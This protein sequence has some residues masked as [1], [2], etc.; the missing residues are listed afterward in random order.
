MTSTPDPKATE[1][2]DVLVKRADE[3]LAHAYEQ[4][5]RADE[6]LARVT[7]QL[8]KLDQDA[9]RHTSA[10][11]GRRPS[12]GRPALRGVIGLLLAAC[13]VAAAFAWQSPYGHAAKLIIARWG[14]QLLSTSP[15]P[16]EKGVVAAQLRPAAVQVAA[17]EPEPP[18][19]APLATQIAPQEAALTGALPSPELGRLLQAMA[20]NLANVEQGIEQLRAN[21]EQMAIDN[22]KA[23][24]QLKA[25]QE[26]MAQLIAKASEQNL[27]PQT[28]APTPRSIATATRKPA[29]SLPS[30]R[31]RAAQPQPPMPLQPPQR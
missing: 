12:R 21:Q 7:E 31:A 22:A 8:S 30:P 29:P 23:V 10:A 2:D 6:Q 28:L 11:P 19:Q 3:R 15:P 14:P 26:Q 5:A 4:I 25:S 9:A 27:R 18:Q 13:I 20:R 16:R 1:P 24:E 17:A